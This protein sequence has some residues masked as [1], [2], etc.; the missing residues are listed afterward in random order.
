MPE[1]VL[2]TPFDE[3]NQTL[4]DHV[5]PLAWENPAP[6]PVYSL[7]V[8]GAGAAGLAAAAA[9]AQLGGRVALV[10][11][12]LLGGDRLNTGSLPTRA[13]L[14]AARAYK[15]AAGAAAFGLRVAV[16]QADFGAAMKWMRE[17]RARLSAQVSAARCREL[18]ID[19]FLGAGRFVGPAAVEVEGRALRFHRAL[20]ATGARPLVPDLPGLEEVGSLTRESVFSLQHL[21][22][23]LAL[24]GSGPL[25]CELAQAFARFGAMVTL[26][27]EEDRLLPSEEPEAAACLRRALEADGVRAVERARLERVERAGRLKGALL[28]GR[29]RVAPAGGRRD[30]VGRGPPAER[31][32][33]RP[34]GG[35]RSGRTSRRRG[36][37]PAAHDEPGDLRG[38]RRLLRPAFP[39]GGRSHGADRRAQRPA[40][41]A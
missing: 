38:R 4:V 24:V 28:R 32:G 37:R 39:P 27:V 22:S 12:H 3:H 8:L 6:A 18:G 35:R 9:T 2:I 33:P 10:E 11:R 36:R 40:R 14:R 16:E 1:E 17:R 13:T 20:I 7:V 31:R 41:R 29:G 19:L 26:L 5:H 30:P 23:R 15:E 21:P 25:A 34:R